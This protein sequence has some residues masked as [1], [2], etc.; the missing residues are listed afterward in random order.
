[1]TNQMTTVPIPEV[2][3]N[4]DVKL[5]L[6]KES[7]FEKIYEIGSDPKVWEQ[8]PNPTRYQKDIF[9]TFFQGALESHA[10]YL[11]YDKKSGELAG[12][13]RFY[14]YN[15]EDNSIFI[16]YTFYATKFWGTGINPK[17]KHLMMDYIFQYVDKI[18]F[19]VGE[20]NKRSRI[21]ME[22]LGAKLKEIIRVAYFGEPDRINAW[23]VIDKP[24]S[25]N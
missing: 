3:E 25:G 10:A 21:A 14:D 9:T 5:V 11:I 20:D 7:D 13:T 4:D 15:E 22:R 24:E 6:V 8:H 19:H 12:S 16:G 2:L 17:V 23:Y 18:N 1:M